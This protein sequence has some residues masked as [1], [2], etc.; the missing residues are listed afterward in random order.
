MIKP[1]ILAMGESKAP[2]LE[3]K[4]TWK[5][6][7]QS[8]LWISDWFENRMGEGDVSSTVDRLLS[9]CGYG[10]ELTQYGVPFYA[11]R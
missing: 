8:G 10:D 5:Q 1:P 2:L 7:G 4:R 3:C 11:A 9:S 6:H